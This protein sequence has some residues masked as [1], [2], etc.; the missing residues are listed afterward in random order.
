MWGRWRTEEAL[1]AGGF[2]R[3]AGVDEAGRGP[4]AGPVVAA[5]AML[6]R[7]CRLPG[8]NDSKL[9]TAAGRER[10]FELIVRRAVSIGV[11]IADARMIDR[12]NVLEATRL[13]MKEAVEQL[14]PQPDVVLVDGWE[15]PDWA[16]PQRALV[17]GDR[18]CGSI[19]AASVVAKVTRD[20]MMRDL[21]E[22]YPGYGFGQ[23]KGYLTRQH[24]ERLQELGPC[25][26]HRLSFA[27]VRALFQGRLPLEEPRR[28]RP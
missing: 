26:E 3:I 18:T 23:H 16:V 21:G 10:L 15:V 9:L 13:A 8:L 19:A 28:G 12:L 4:L 17:G 22:L 1:R 11:G 7:G 5:A 20:R 27:P 14:E 2:V 24:E 25:P 6:P